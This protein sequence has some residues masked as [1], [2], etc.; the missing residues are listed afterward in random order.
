MSVQF[1]DKR[2]HVLTAFSVE[3]ENKEE[4]RRIHEFQ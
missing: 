4:E 2:A 1:E 3:F